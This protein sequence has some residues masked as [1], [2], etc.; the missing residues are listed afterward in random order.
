MTHHLIFGLIQIFSH[1]VRVLRAGTSPSEGGCVWPAADKN[2][3]AAKTVAGFYSAG[4]GAGLCV[5]HRDAEEK[6]QQ[7]LAV[8]E[9]P[10]AGGE[11]LPP[12]LGEG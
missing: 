7:W 3:S 2:W 5:K 11:R 6:K 4:H 1:Q 10:S 12:C 8:L 9:L